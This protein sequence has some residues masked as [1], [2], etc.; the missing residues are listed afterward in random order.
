VER[1]SKGHALKFREQLNSDKRHY[2]WTFHCPGCAAWDEPGHHLHSTHTVDRTWTFNGDQDK[3]TLSPSVL[4]TGQFW[5]GGVKE[6]RRCH[7]FV[8]EGRIEFLADC[9]HSLAGKTVD[10]PEIQ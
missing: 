7:S 3:P 4:V 2:G 6:E 10:L 9:T 1:F 8:R 5:V